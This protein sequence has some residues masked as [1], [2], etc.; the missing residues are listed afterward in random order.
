MKSVF[1]LVL[2]VGFM[3]AGSVQAKSADEKAIH[4]IINEMALGAEQQ[5]AARL[6]AILSDNFRVVLNDT[7]EKVVKVLDKTT[8]LGFI[9]KK[10]FGGETYELTI[11]RLD[12]LGGT[13]AT[14]TVT[15]KGNKTTMEKSY[16]FVKVDGEWQLV[17]DL[18]YMGK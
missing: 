5:D 12:V 16:S 7:K 6:D 17:Q 4:H 9:E 18:V 13:T 10:V 8:Y 3:F 1:G 11:H 14:A 15:Q 2:V